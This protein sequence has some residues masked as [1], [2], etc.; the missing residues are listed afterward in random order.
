MCEDAIDELP[1]HLSRALGMVVERGNGR[2]DNGSCFRSQLHVAKMNA[3]E[4]RFAYAEDERAALLEADIRGAMDEIAGKAIGDGRERSHR[5]GKDDHGASGVTSTRDGGADVG[6]AVLANL[7][8]WSAEEFFSQVVT[9]AEL[10]L[11]REYT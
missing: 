4:R 6:V 10:E 1:G 9:S 5:A 7:A 3:I 11:F 2:K 8:A